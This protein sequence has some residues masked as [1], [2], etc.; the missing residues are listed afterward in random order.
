MGLFD[1]VIKSEL[2]AMNRPQQTRTATAL[3]GGRYTPQP[4]IGTR[5]GVT[6]E[7]KWLDTNG[8]WRMGCSCGWEDTKL[9]WTRTTAVDEGNRHV[10]GR[11]F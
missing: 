1:W 9:R 4:V 11:R 10:K 5:D 8:R 7:L 6:H 2:P 3:F